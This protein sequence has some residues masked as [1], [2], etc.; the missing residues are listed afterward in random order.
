[1]SGLEKPRVQA[2]MS[3]LPQIEERR[4]LGNFINVEIA[5]AL[6]YLLSARPKPVLQGLALHRADN[7]QTHGGSDQAAEVPEEEQSASGGNACIQRTSDKAEK[8]SQVT[9]WRLR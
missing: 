4:D 2:V 6:E 1:M 5:A 8:R 3:S 9:K 7:P